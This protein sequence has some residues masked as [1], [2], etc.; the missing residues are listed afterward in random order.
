MTLAL[1]S[2]RREDSIRSDVEVHL[3]EALGISSS[4]LMSAIVDH[5]QDTIFSLQSSEQLLL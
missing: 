1:P 4:N 5:K 2:D 3:G